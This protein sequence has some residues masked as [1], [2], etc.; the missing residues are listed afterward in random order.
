MVRALNAVYKRKK[1]TIPIRHQKLVLRK[2][3]GVF[4]N[5]WMPGSSFSVSEM[6]K[7]LIKSKAPPLRGHTVGSVAFN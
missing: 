6:K 5:S 7:A 1:V 2:M 4:S 3:K